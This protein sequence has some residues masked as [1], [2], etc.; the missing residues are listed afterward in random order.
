MLK[1]L[2][3]S[4]RNQQVQSQVIHLLRSL[5]Q[6]KAAQMLQQLRDDPDLPAA[7][8]SIQAN[9]SLSLSARPSDLRLARAVAPPTGST[10]EFE[11]AAQFS[12]A[13]PR[14]PPPDKQALRGLLRQD[15][16]SQITLPR[17]HIPDIPSSVPQR[18]S[19]V[20]TPLDSGKYCDSRL[21]RLEI[22]Y[23]SKVSIS[24]ADAA[25]LVS[26]YIKTDHRIMGLFDADL[27]LEDLVERRQRFCSPFLVSAILCFSIVGT[28]THYAQDYRNISQN[29]SRLACGLY[30]LC[31]PPVQ[32]SAFLS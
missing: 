29:T 5:P 21:E 28:S 11:L 7:I 31:F 22:G 9:N 1:R 2:Q 13:Y 32:I 30:S 4:E 26:F 15:G 8:S 17:N 12:M 10:T 18:S 20:S 19:Q 27:F 23:W 24:N 14:I 6:H 25:S 16:G 3:D